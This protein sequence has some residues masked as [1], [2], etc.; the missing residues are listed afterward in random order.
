MT[1]IPK[2]KPFLDMM[3]K[4]FIIQRF[5]HFLLISKIIC[6][7]FRTFQTYK[8]A[9]DLC[10][11]ML[12]IGNNIAFSNFKHVIS[13]FTLYRLNQFKMN[14][15]LHVIKI[16]TYNSFFCLW[17]NTPIVYQITADLTA[18]QSSSD[19]SLRPRAKDGFR[20]YTQTAQ[21]LGRFEMPAV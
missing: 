15:L 21:N 20:N 7:V 17:L 10:L 18:A 11:T 1:T 16:K 13:K 3:L 8:P 2:Y 5:Y 4:D 19:R 14:K 6:L 9:I 12:Q